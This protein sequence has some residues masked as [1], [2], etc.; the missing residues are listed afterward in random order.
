[1]LSS[2]EIIDLKENSITKRWK[3]EYT[4]TDIYRA[5]RVLRAMQYLK[6]AKVLRVWYDDSQISDNQ[7]VQDAIK[8]LNE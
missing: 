2:P 1:M 6:N 3:Q 7:I 4:E 5:S 8:M